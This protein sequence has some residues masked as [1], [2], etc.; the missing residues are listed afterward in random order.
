[1][2]RQL[3]PPPARVLEVGSGG[4]WLALELARCGYDVLGVEPEAEAVALARCVAAGEPRRPAYLCAAIEDRPPEPLDAAVF[5]LSL[6][7]VRDL[8]GTLR[9]LAG[10]LRPGGRLVCVEC[11]SLPRLRPPSWPNPGWRNSA[12]TSCTGTKR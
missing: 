3:P 2:S 8:A 10:A 4:G 7:H 11:P 5:H 6:H 12:S 9:K 1:M